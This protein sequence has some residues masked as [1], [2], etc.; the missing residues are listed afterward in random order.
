MQ[1]A[2]LRFGHGNRAHPA[3][4]LRMELEALPPELLEATSSPPWVPARWARDEKYWS[5]SLA[6]VACRP[7]TVEMAHKINANSHDVRIGNFK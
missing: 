6:A 7:T 1:G 2:G 3:P 4:K 5:E